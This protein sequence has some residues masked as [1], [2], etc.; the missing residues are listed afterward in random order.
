MRSLIP[1]RAIGT[2]ELSDFITSSLSG[3]GGAD[4]HVLV[5]IPDD[6]RFGLVWMGRKTLATAFDME[7][8]FNDVA[9]TLTP[10]ASED[11]VITRSPVPA[12]P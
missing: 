1:E 3:F 6:T 12:A 8:G 7:G 9:L 10:E 4:E 11:E 5:I 2:A